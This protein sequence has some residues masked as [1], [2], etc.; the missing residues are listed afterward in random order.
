MT[1]PM[2]A[3]ATISRE[4]LDTLAQVALLRLPLRHAEARRL[5]RMHTVLVAAGELCRTMSAQTHCALVNCR[6]THGAG[7]L[8]HETEAFFEALTKYAQ[9]VRDVAGEY[10]GLTLDAPPPALEPDARPRRLEV[11]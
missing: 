7:S 1:V 2:Q 9:L 4:D 3:N 11:A 6:G 10:R 5:D 8:P